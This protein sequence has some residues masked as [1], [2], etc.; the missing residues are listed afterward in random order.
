[1]SNT[2]SELIR[3]IAKWQKIPALLLT[4][5]STGVCILPIRNGVRRWAGLERDVWLLNEVYA[6]TAL[7]ILTAGMCLS[8]D[9]LAEIEF[10][11]RI[12]L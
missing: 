4:A 7:V 5:K 9:F 10:G 8:F 11:T 3:K 6:L 12:F 1:L 2:P